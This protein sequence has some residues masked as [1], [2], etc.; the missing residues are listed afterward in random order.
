MEYEK[1]I[2]VMQKKSCKI[3]FRINN[4]KFIQKHKHT[5]RGRC[6]GGKRA[7]E[8]RSINIMPQYLHAKTNK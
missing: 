8:K 7:A 1:I 5:F 3:S 2:D 6:D 4:S